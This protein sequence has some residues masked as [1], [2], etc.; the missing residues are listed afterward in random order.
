MACCGGG[1]WRRRAQRTLAAP[2]S[3]QTKG[4]EPAPLPPQTYVSGYELLPVIH[5]VH[6]DDALAAEV[7]VVGVH[8]QEQHVWG[9]GGRDGQVGS[10][11]QLAFSPHPSV[12]GPGGQ[13]GRR[14]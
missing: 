4:T 2:G 9:R 7:V 3:S 8:G 10:V 14:A 11:C 13:P 5:V 1:G 12:L 6:G